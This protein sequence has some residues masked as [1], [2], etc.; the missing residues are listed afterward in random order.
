MLSLVCDFQQN[1]PL[2]LNPKF[3][4]GVKSILCDTTLDKVRLRPSAKFSLLL[5]SIRTN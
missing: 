2:V 1:K 5:Q 3:V 4:D